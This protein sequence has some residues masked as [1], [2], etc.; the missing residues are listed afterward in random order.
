M[1]KSENLI[2]RID[3]EMKSVIDYKAI[4]L[5]VTTS[6]LVREI[7]SVLFMV[8]Y[9]NQR[10]SNY[11]LE[12]IIEQRKFLNQIITYPFIAEKHQLKLIAKRNLENLIVLE[13]AISNP[14]SGKLD[15]STFTFDMI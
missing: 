3:P 6:K 13:K 9:E 2:V 4:E 12:K 10:F 8:E 7:L 15:H 14:L 1:K 5:E 11:V